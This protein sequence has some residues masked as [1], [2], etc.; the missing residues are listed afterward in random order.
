MVTDTVNG[1]S[2]VD[3]S[4]L[5]VDSLAPGASDTQ[6]YVYD[7]DGTE[8]DPLPNS[9]TVTANGATSDEAATDTDSCRTDVTHAPGIDVTKS[10]PET[11]AFGE[12]ITYTIT[13]T[14]TGNEALEGVTV[15][16]TLLGDITDQFDVDFS[17]PFGVGEVATATV[18]YSPG[19]DEDPVDNTV[20]AT[21]T[22]V[23]SGA[24]ASAHDS[25]RTDITHA[26][27]IDV[28]KSCPET[29][30]FGE[31]ITYTI[32][33]TNTGNEALEGVTVDDTLLGDITDQF[34]VDFSVPFGVG[35]VATATVTYSPGADEDPVDNTV[36][37]T[38]TGVDS[39][40]EASAHDSCRTDVTHA[41]GIDV[42]KSCPETVAFGEDI[43]YTITVTNTGN[44]ALEGVTVD[45]TL[46][47]DIT[48]QFDVDFSVPFGVGEVA[49]ATVTYSPGADEDPVVNSVTASG[50]G[51]DSGVQATD[52]AVCT[53][54]VSNPGISIEKTVDQEVA[55]IG[56]TVT[57]T[58]VV[59]NTGDVTLYNIS[60]DDDILGHI[61]DIAQLDPGQS[62]TLTKDAQV[63]A[64]IVTNIGTAVGHDILG[65]EVSASDDATVAPI[66]GENPPPPNPPDPVHGLG[67]GTARA[68][69]DGSVR[70]RRDRG[71]VDPQAPTPRASPR[72]TGSATRR[73]GSRSGTP[74]SAFPV[75]SPDEDQRHPQVPILGIDADPDAAVATPEDVLLAEVVSQIFFWCM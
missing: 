26:P 6:E 17:V 67:R 55:P 39:G 1:N 46:L 69:H 51:V 33:V 28:T 41:P 53:S 25:C 36:T 29:V 71:R 58:Y 37:A 47:G 59:T 49:T 72:N 30:A 68:H 19:A 50:D 52:T 57:F 70:D 15:D 16:D 27:G 43:T 18:T 56:T 74:P 38:G 48:D 21:G 75:R 60:V 14:N 22:G 12:D 13:V 31:D 32:T 44:E 3:I 42:T 73:A 24:E 35:E 11:V 8:P 20:T 2:P 5:F 62:A 63:T 54:D 7:A 4:N 10:C 9:A 40:A 65:R 61:G 34:D 23:D 45:D 64:E 66:S